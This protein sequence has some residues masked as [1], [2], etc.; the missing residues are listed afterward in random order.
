ML[1]AGCCRVP[2]YTTVVKHFARCSCFA[3]TGST[4]ICS[5][6]CVIEKLAF[7]KTDLGAIVCYPKHTAGACLVIL[8]DAERCFSDGALIQL[9]SAA[10]ALFSHIPSKFRHGEVQ[11][12]RSH[13][14]C[15]SCP[16]NI[17]E[18][19]RVEGRKNGRRISDEN[20]AT[21]PNIVID[22]IRKCIPTLK[23]HVRQCQLT[24]RMHGEKAIWDVGLMPVK[25]G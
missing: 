14:E 21:L 13:A 2:T 16:R 15:P 18:E 10:S 3:E 7:V 12:T 17:I 1:R 5:S 25:F 6:F 4:P 19:M 11:C 24:T 8:K 20:C 9:Q 22:L 23:Y